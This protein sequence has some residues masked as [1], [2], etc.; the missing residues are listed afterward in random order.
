MSVDDFINIVQNINNTFYQGLIVTNFTAD[1]NI[2]CFDDLYPTLKYFPKNDFHE[3]LID[4]IKCKNITI[5]FD[6]LC[7]IFYMCDNY[8]SVRIIENLTHFIQVEYDVEKLIGLLQLINDNDKL[9]VCEHLKD[10]IKCIDD[11][12]CFD[13]VFRLYDARS[14]ARLAKIL[15]IEI[16]KTESTSS[17]ISNRY[18]VINTGVSNTTLINSNIVMSQTLFG[19][20]SLQKKNNSAVQYFYNQKY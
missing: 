9:S 12:A 6:D 16:D 15:N 5:T 13:K 14:K 7:K 2:K 4:V 1:V 11:K 18:S 19:G 8:Q 20:K 17:T 3:I 10:K